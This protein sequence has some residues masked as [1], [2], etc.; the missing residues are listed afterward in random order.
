MDLKETLPDLT[1]RWFMNP[2][3]EHDCWDSHDPSFSRD[4]IYSPDGGFVP[5]DSN[6]RLFYSPR[7]PFWHRRDRRKPF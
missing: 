3:L 5:R 6:S 2:V 4:Q 1:Q 7:V